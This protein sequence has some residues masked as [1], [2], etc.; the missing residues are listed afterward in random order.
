VVD[1]ERE[2]FPWPMIGL[3]SFHTFDLQNMSPQQ[4]QTPEI[5]CRRWFM[6]PH[7][8]SEVLYLL[9]P[10]VIKHEKKR[11]LTASF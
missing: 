11:E 8:D 5:I 9:R 3:F 1:D 4:L 2:I 7:Q 10:G 6:R